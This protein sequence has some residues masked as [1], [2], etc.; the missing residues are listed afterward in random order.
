VDNEQPILEFEP[1][2]YIGL[3][4]IIDGEEVRRNYSLSAL[5][6]MW[7]ATGSASSASRAGGVQLPA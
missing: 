5:A 4:L 3:K 1:G 7:A 2:Q 6:P